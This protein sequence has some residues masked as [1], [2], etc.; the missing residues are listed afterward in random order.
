MSETAMERIKRWAKGLLVLVLALLGGDEFPLGQYDAKPVDPEE[1][2]D[3]E[4][5]FG[6][7][8][9]TQGGIH[10]FNQRLSPAEQRRIAKWE[11]GTAA[12]EAPA[13]QAPH[14]PPCL[15][16]QRPGLLR[17]LRGGPGRTVRR[18]PHTPMNDKRGVTQ[19]QARH[20]A[21]V[22]CPTPGETYEGHHLAV[23][24]FGCGCHRRPA[25]GRP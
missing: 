7:V 3:G 17:G 15:R 4:P 19:R 1:D 5:G 9:V 12:L 21:G 22:W 23:A 20:P 11:E 8:L 6:P 13:G 18:S 2:E 16:R 14:R 10:M 25:R 24:E